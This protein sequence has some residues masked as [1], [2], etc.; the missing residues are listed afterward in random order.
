VVIRPGRIGVFACM[1]TEDPCVLDC[2]GRT[3]AGETS[4]R[5]AQAGRENLGRIVGLCF[6][7]QASGVYRIWLWKLRDPVPELQ[8][9]RV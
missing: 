2:E 1:L 5:H 6:E 3:R 7:M 8:V 4:A 9:S